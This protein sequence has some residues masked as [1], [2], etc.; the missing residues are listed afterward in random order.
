MNRVMNFNPGP[1][2]L[3]LEALE[4]ARDELLDF[5][6]TGMSIIE[7]S[8]R[9]EAYE[10]VH[11]EAMDLT[12]ELLDLPAEYDV[13]LLQGGASQQFAL[14]PMNY[15]RDG[16]SAGYLVTGSWSDKALAEAKSVAAILG[17]HIQVVA[18]SA[19]EE[20]GGRTYSRLPTS[21][22]IRPSPD[23]AYVHVTSNETIE[24][25]EFPSDTEGRIAA[26]P[27]GR[28]LVA[29]MSSDFLA[30]KIDVSR[31]ALIYAGAQK[32]IGPSG[33]VVV[34]AQRE[35]IAQGRDDIPT[36]FR[37]ST[38]SKSK[39]LYN[40][41]PSFAVYLLR[42]VLRWMKAAGGLNA[43]EA[44]NRRKAARLYNVIDANADFY[45]CPVD[46]GSRSIMNIV[47]RLPSEEL[48]DRFIETAD[49]EGMVGLRGH[50]SVGGVRVSCYNAVGL[51][52]VEALATYME[53]FAA[54][55][56]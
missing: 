36:I 11:F 5:Q 46:T 38:H 16:T 51:D 3:P 25:M 47:F 10:A 17:A 48:E 54:N 13:L 6:G 18:T 2:A 22:E 39:S 55:G 12:R 49:K 41:P 31:Y 42:N 45:R 7:H 30:R 1:A 23:L 40:T 34:L 53:R 14:V 9:G 24:G 37:Y 4:A 52:W 50:R 56:A 35:F 21:E 33:L 15:L 28:A 32:N 19:Q 43:I 26:F 44:L 20:R 27:S 29:D 8:H